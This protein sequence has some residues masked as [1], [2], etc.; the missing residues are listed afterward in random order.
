MPDVT[1]RPVSSLELP[2]V[3]WAKLHAQLADRHNT[4][5]ISHRRSFGQMPLLV[6]AVIVASV[7]Y[8]PKME[9]VWSRRQYPR[10]LRSMRGL[11]PD[12]RGV[13]GIVAP[14]RL[15]LRKPRLIMLP[16]V[17]LHA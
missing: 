8:T 6:A 7:N 16:G 9:T 12:R 11:H 14:E 5:A 4:F 1:E 17:A 3:L 10:A 15:C 13:D 2:G